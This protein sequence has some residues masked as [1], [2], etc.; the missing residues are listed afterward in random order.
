M[1]TPPTISAGRLR[2]ASNLTGMSEH[3]TPRG[4]AAVSWGP[5]RID[6]FTVDEDAG[7]VHRVFVSGTWMA[8]ESL[9]G[10]LASAPAVAAWAVDQLQ[11]F[12]IFPDGA[13]W[14]RYWDGT[15]WHA[16]ESLGGELTGAPTASS[17]VRG[18]DRCLRSGS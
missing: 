7:L 12:A 13:L 15:S 8:S 3:A 4:A 6:L 11:V 5:D 10:T 9:G 16:W 18:P 1:H 2:P 14:N 17:W